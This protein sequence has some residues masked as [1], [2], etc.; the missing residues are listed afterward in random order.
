MTST[1]IDRFAG[2]SSSVAVKA[3]VAT[4]ADTPITLYGE[5]TVNGVSVVA[6]DRVLVMAQS[7]AVDNG[8][9]DVSTGVWTRSADFDGSRDVVKGTI[10][11]TNHDVQAMYRVTTSNPIL[12]GSSSIEFQELTLTGPA[13]PPGTPGDAGD[14]TS[15]YYIAQV[16]GGTAIKNGL[17]TITLEAHRL[18]GGTDIK[19]TS[20]TVQLYVGST[21]CTEANGYHT[22][23]D[24]YTAVFDAG[25]IA[26]SCVVTLKNGAGGEALD[27]CALVDIA[28]G[29][30]G[31]VGYDAVYGYIECDGSL[32]W[33]RASDQV[34]WTPSGGSRKMDVTFIQGGV[35]VARVAWL[36]TRAADGTLTGASTTHTAGDLNA[37]RVSVS[38][39][40][41]GTQAFTVKFTYSYS[42]DTCVVAE[43]LYTSLSGATGGT[44]PTGPTGPAPLVLS[45][46]RPTVM[47]PAYT[48]GT[49]PDYS[50]AVGQVTVWSGTTD[51]TA[52]ATLSSAVT[53]VTGSVNTAL[54]TP[55]TGAKG[56]YRVTGMSAA[57]GYLTITAVYGGATVTSQFAVTKGTVGIEKVAS[58]PITN[59]Y[60]GRAVILTTTGKLYRYYGG[61]WTTAVDGADLVASSVTA[62]AILAGTI[63][64]AKIA[65]GTV[66]GENMNA[67]QFNIANAGAT[68]DMTNARISM[69]SSGYYRITGVNFGASSDLVDYFGSG[70]TSTA[71]ESNAKFLIKNDGTAIFAGR[72]RGEYEPKMWV[73][74]NGDTAPPTIKDRYNVSTVEKYT[75]GGSST[76]RY[77]I[78][79]ASSLP[80]SNY[81]CVTGGSDSSKIVILTV[82]EQTTTYV[83]VETNKRGDG[84]YIDVSNLNVLVFGSNV[85][86]GDNVS[87]PG[88]GV[89]GGTIGG[90]YLP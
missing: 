32:A 84:G 81:C 50:D 82:V 30:T 62:N 19:L 56:S 70:T 64:S 61:S 89:G 47:L 52:T 67:A 29:T 33:V 20:G 59:L 85:V 44:G 86:G 57:S 37:G 5:Q 7:S 11:I 23:S 21:L 54:N 79:F 63:T 34:S 36:V 88:G 90:G 1:S 4:V 26:G 74:I 69:Y 18:V 39:I 6:G 15:L 48:D 76:G 65:A 8:I 2:L 72:T 27:T 87:T 3:P 53:N 58:L 46:S 31:G 25:D 78:N 66:T 41:E 51:V 16:N 22:G 13:G 80:N 49:V 77:K 42:S 24:G 45:L 38:E 40:N 55:V 83:K 9:Y 43:T 12:P 60:T 35:A 28:D 68:I 14:S 71:A 17:G 73:N 75:V 10:V